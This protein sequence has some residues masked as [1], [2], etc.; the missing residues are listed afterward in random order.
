LVSPIGGYP[1]VTVIICRAKVAKATICCWKNNE[2]PK[3]IPL[4]QSLFGNLITHLLVW[5]DEKE[6]YKMVAPLPINL[7][8]FST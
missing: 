3:K 2:N 4:Q 6:H 5:R 7:Q 1:L 8:M